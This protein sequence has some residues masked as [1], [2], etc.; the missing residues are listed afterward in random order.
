MTEKSRRARV[1][2]LSFHTSPLD[3][4]GMG[5]SGGMNVYIRAVAERLAAQGVGVDIFTRCAGR[6]VP[7][8]QEVADGNRV[9]QVHAGPCAPVPKA[10]LPGFLRAFLSGVLTRERHEGIGYDVVHSH[11]WLSGWVGQNAKEILGVPLV[12]SFH[13]LAKVKNSSLALGE[14]PE[15]GE[16]I[17]GEEEVIAGA[18]RI[19]APTPAEAAHLVDLYAADPGRIRIVP[20]GVDHSLFFPRDGER[21]KARLHL[22]GVRLVL[23]VGRLQP[24]KGPDIAVRALAEAV[25]RHPGVMRDVV[26]AIVGGPAG[27]QGTA[28]V[29]GLMD[30]A[31]AEGVGDR[32][33]FF[34]PQPQARLA[35]FYSAAEAVLV[36]S[37]TESFGLVALEALACGAPVVAAG[38]GGLR[39]LVLDG[40]NGYLVPGHDPAAYADRL[41]ALLSDPAAGRRMGQAGVTHAL[42][43]SWDRTAAQVLSV[44]G[45]LL[46]GRM[47][48]PRSS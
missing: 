44:Y 27:P 46:G 37:R 26:L 38:T 16:R 30:L 6:R 11:Y 20:P 36:P 18:D 33:M 45:E 7:E 13:T 3:Q 23:F 25:A 15:P 42:R 28:E 40:E 19:L 9:I 8:V 12:V 43:F 35:D 24:H 41:V 48:A 1:A 5:D 22:A 32:V 2:V 4:P 10:E 39:Y 47:G 29:A 14:G 34:P 21:A 31:A 17:A